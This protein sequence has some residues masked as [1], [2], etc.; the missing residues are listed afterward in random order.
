VPQVA[1]D[2]GGTAEAVTPDTGRLVAPHDPA[3]LA[4]AI[5]ALV[6]DG[7]LRAR[8]AGA[9]RRRH[10]EVFGAARVVAETAAV[11]RRV[12]SAAASTNGDRRAI[13]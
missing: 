9:S 1:T 13:A 12:L 4:D 8:M 6:A 11:Y 7:R 10:A 5:V 3:A 2:V